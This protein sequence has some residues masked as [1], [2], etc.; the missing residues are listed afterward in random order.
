[1]QDAPKEEPEPTT[2]EPTV[3]V[4]TVV[5]TTSAPAPEATTTAPAPAEPDHD[6]GG[7]FGKFMLKVRADDLL[8]QTSA[9]IPNKRVTEEAVGDAL[10]TLGGCG[11]KDCEAH[12]GTDR[13]RFPGVWYYE[14][15]Y[16]CKTC[17]QDALERVACRTKSSC[18]AAT[19]QVTKLGILQQ[20][21]PDEV[22]V[23]RICSPGDCP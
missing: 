10:S 21:Q 1:V 3:T 12:L 20:L 19:Q 4:A 15:K 18:A 8:G 22:A 7:P 11:E 5:E 2:A 14:F 23:T 9:G 17:A 13:E 6:L 16:A